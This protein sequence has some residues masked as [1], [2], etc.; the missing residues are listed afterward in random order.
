MTFTRYLYYKPN[1]VGSLFISIFANNAEEA[2]FWGYEL[3]YSGF[4]N[5]L[6][7]YLLYISENPLVQCKTNGLLEPFI[8]SKQYFST[9]KFIRKKYNE[10]IT[11][12]KTDQTRDCIIGTIIRN[13]TLC[14][15]NTTSKTIRIIYKDKDI[16]KYRE[17]IVAIKPYLF[18]SLNCIYPVRTNTGSLIIP[19]QF[20]ENDYNY[21]EILENWRTG[22]E[23]HSAKSPFWWNIFEL[24]SGSLNHQNKTIEFKNEDCEERFYEKYG[25]E[26]DEQSEEI[27]IK[28]LGNEIM[29]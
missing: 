16:I 19:K 3:Y 26:P 17:P 21:N 8:K 5:D 2:I 10:F 12:P 15:T 20:I 4:E 24:F 6:L 11:L 13:L 18:L 28:C 22:W 29:Q 9:V 23:Y 27:R 1:V 25:Y 14:Q 7:E